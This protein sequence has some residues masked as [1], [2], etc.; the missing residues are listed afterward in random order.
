MSLRQLAVYVDSHGPVWHGMWTNGSINTSWSWRANGNG[1]KW[2]YVECECRYWSRDYNEC[3]PSHVCDQRGHTRSSFWLQLYLHQHLVNTTWPAKT[4]SSGWWISTKAHIIGFLWH[5]WRFVC[6]KT[7]ELSI[8][9][10]AQKFCTCAKTG[11]PELAGPIAWVFPSFHYRCTYFCI[12]TRA[13]IVKFTIGM[14][15]STVFGQGDPC[16]HEYIVQPWVSGCF[17]R[18]I[19]FVIEQPPSDKR[20]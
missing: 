7:E 6:G 16:Q 11:C 9:K 3:Y 2:W 5:Y 17:T 8:L 1:P 12:V 18:L 14:L 10:I 13:E 15:K 19:S 4:L 20:V